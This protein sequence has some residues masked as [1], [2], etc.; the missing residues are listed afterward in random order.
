[1]RQHCAQDLPGCSFSSAGRIH[2]C[3]GAHKKL[4]THVLETSTETMIRGRDPSNVSLDR[5]TGRPVSPQR[6][7]GFHSDVLQEPSW[8]CAVMDLPI[9]QPFCEKK[10]TCCKQRGRP[11]GN[12]CRLPFPVKSGARQEKSVLQLLARSAHHPRRALARVSKL[13]AHDEAMTSS[14]ILLAPLPFCGAYG[15]GDRRRASRRHCK[16]SNSR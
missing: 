3:R 12:T 8:L 1:M 11:M 13:Q 6:R 7:S 2:S 4:A 14:R 15:R 9:S 5:I 16:N 10:Q